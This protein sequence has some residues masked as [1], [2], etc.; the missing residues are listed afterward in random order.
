M[1]ARDDVVEF[2]GRFPS[3]IKE[4]IAGLSEGDLRWRP[5]PQEWSI[6]E[7][8]AHLRDTIEIEGLRLRALLAAEAAVLPSYDE[9]AYARQRLYN[10]DDIQRVL[11]GLE[12]SVAFVIG[13]VKG[14]S[15]ADW[16]RQGRHEE[17][18]PVTVGSR[19]SGLIEHGRT[20][21]AQIE[22]IRQQLPR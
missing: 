5:G 1:T 17:A 19:A 4:A 18:G 14:L 2:F 21:L 11:T 12:S 8:C 3:M 6:Q 16:Q 7:V 13:T 22:S 15:E 9:S 20:H 10:Y